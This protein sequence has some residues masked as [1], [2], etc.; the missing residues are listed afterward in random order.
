MELSQFIPIF[1]IVINLRRM[2]V[3]R[4]FFTIMILLGLLVSIV[5]YQWK[6]FSLELESDKEI[7]QTIRIKHQDGIF[8]VHQT[9][10]N[11]PQETYNLYIPET[12]K[13]FSCY[14]GEKEECKIHN[15]LITINNEK[16]N[17][18]YELNAP[19]D[20]SSFLFHDSFIT[21]S[22]L[23]ISKTHIQISEYEWR[24]GNWVS[25]AN[26]LYSKELDYLDYYIFSHDNGS[27]PLFWHDEPLKSTTINKHVLLYTTEQLQKNFPLNSL[28]FHPIQSDQ[29]VVIITNDQKEQ[30]LNS[31]YFINETNDIKELESKLYLL[32]MNRV[33]QWNGSDLW[34]Q[35][36][37]LSLFT[38]EQPKEA[39]KQIYE[40]LLNL[41]SN[42]E[43]QQLKELIRQHANQRITSELLDDLIGKI[44]NKKV[45]FFTIN[46]NS[47][48]KVNSPI[49][50][51]ARDIFVANEL[52]ENIDLLRENNKDWIELETLLQG[53]QYDVSFVDQQT[54]VATKGAI[55]YRFF[56]DK[57]Y[58]DFNMNRY[59]TTNPPI[60]TIHN[61]PFIELPLVET[62]FNVQVYEF[63]DRIEIK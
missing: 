35:D 51:D 46:T 23:P 40:E 22:Q 49:I 52:I 3:K 61:K 1:K 36:I 10:T 12:V 14:A 17:L 39:N 45:K 25:S 20:V 41:L 60:I 18:F 59:G 9:I 29:V 53:L 58:F 24:N 50:L 15:R 62:F 27:F 54:I 28:H 5:F 56:P 43:L 44:V 11:L 31:L 42:E 21:I 13:E 37:L 57:R 2:Q 30:Y 33:F 6:T 55:H 7:E 47:E 48:E 26:S 16:I 38:E 32:E 19:T 34:L 63:E 4:A 8:K